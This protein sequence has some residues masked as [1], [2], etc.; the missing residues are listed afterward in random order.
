MICC[1][2]KILWVNKSV[3]SQFHEFCI[4]AVSTERRFIIESLLNSIY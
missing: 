2:Q 1:L 4:G 3:S